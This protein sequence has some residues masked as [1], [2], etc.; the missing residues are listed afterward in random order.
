MTKF[1]WKAVQ[2]FLEQHNLTPDDAMQVILDNL[3]DKR[4]KHGSGKK[5][6]RMW[7][8]PMIVST[9]TH[10]LAEEDKI[11]KTTNRKKVQ[12]ELFKSKAC[13]TFIVTAGLKYSSYSNFKNDY[14]KWKRL[15]MF[16]PSWIKGTITLDKLRKKVAAK[17]KILS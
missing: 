13:G 4:W 17:N 9:F 5:L 12:Q 7:T 2:I 14:S 10:V 8:D 11:A 6:G 15:P 16:K 3:F 1:T